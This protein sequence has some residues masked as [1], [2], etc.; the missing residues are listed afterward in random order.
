MLHLN[1][2][3]SHLREMHETR[4]VQHMERSKVNY[5]EED[6]DDKGEPQENSHAADLQSIQTSLQQ[7][8]GGVHQWTNR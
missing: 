7:K 2:E 5:Q 4:K 3:V 1:N 8:D 6:N